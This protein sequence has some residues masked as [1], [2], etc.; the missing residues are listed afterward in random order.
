MTCSVLSCGRAVP[1]P[2]RA[3]AGGNAAGP[4]RARPGSATDLSQ[5]AQNP[6]TLMQCSQTQQPDLLIHS[7]VACYILNAS[8]PV[9][10]ATGK[11]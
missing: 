8:P 2:G 5:D 3:R 10:V 1:W 6:V 11:P 7:Y 9:A 4:A